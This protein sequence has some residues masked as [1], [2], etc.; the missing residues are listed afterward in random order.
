MRC[1]RGNAGGGPPQPA[2]SAPGA[3]VGPRRARGRVPPAG[4]GRWG[5]QGRGSGPA[6]PPVPV[7]DPRVQR[8]GPGG[9]TRALCPALR[10]P[11]G[12]RDGDR[13]GA[14]PLSSAQRAAGA[15]PF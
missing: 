15:G 5:R 3:Q 8:V 11:F 7:L 14:A 2:E 13:D 10:K 4:G 12:P 6:P 9:F 1:C